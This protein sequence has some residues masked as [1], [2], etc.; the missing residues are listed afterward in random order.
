MKRKLFF[1]RTMKREIKM[2]KEKKNNFITQTEL[3]EIKTEKGQR[4]C[5][6]NS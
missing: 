4:F 6:V 1:F 2:E 5:V 3:F